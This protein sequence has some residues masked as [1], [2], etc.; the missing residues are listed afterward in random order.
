MMNLGMNERAGLLC[1]SCV[2]KADELRVDVQ[3][4][5]SGAHVLDMGVQVP[6]GLA[7]GR[8]LAEICMGGLGHVSF[9]PL[10]IGGDT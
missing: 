7:A 4:L 3:V 5:G 1:D 9:V 2:A 8:A 6:G 10:T